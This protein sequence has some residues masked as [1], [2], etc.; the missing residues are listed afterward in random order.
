MESHLVRRSVNQ[1]NDRNGMKQLWT[2][3]LPEFREKQDHCD[4]ENSLET[5]T[6]SDLIAMGILY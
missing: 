4:V 1:A 2:A 6:A 5:Y 3:Q